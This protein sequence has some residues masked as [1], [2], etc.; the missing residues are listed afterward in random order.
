M[1]ITVAICM[2]TRAKLLDQTPAGV[3]GL[4]IPARI[5]WELLAMNNNCTDDT[6]EVIE[7]H[8]RTLPIQRP[9]EPKHGR[10]TAHNLAVH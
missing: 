10:S 3:H 4:R 7:R 1:L 2:W 8:A 9:L 6:D 5:E